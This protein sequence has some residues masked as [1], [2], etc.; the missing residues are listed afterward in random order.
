M[1]MATSLG[2]LRLQVNVA[3]GQC[4]G[5]MRSSVDKAGMGGYISQPG[6]RLNNSITEPDSL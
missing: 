3:S 2:G 5:K 6:R 1:V 4:L